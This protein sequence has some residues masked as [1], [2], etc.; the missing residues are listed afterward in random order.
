MSDRL[1]QPL[2]P[3]RSDRRPAYPAGNSAGLA[4][5]DARWA[6]F[7][8]YCRRRARSG[9]RGRAVKLA[10]RVAAVTLAVTLAVALAVVWH[11]VG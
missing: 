10:F 3:Q 9:G 4:M 1:A 2:S 6:T 7:Q 5:S 8:H 11:H